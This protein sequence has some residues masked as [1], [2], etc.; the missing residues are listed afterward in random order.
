LLVFGTLII[1]D[2][3]PASNKL[4]ALKLI[5]WWLLREWTKK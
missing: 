4:E 1:D 5:I 3:L 2:A